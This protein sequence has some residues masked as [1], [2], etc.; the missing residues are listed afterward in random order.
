MFVFPSGSATQH[1]AQINVNESAGED[2]ASSGA[3]RYNPVVVS[4]TDHVPI[5]SANAWRDRVERTVDQETLLATQ[6]APAGDDPGALSY[7]EKPVYEL[8]GSSSLAVWPPVRLEAFD[9]PTP[10]RDTF[11]SDSDVHAPSRTSDSQVVPPE[12][13]LATAQMVRPQIDPIP[14]ASKPTCSLNLVCYRSGSSGCKLHQV[15]VTQSIKFEKTEDFAKAIMADRDLIT[16]DAE[17]FR[18]LRRAYLSEMCGFW[19]RFFF[20]KNLRGF[21]LLSVRQQTLGMEQ[22][23][24]VA[25]YTQHSRPVVVP[26]DNFVLQEILYAFNHPSKVDTHHDWIDWVFQLRQPDKRHALEFVE[27]WN[28]TRIAVAGSVPM[29]FSTL[30]GLIWSI[31]SGDWQ[32]A[33]TVASFILTLGTLL[34]A[35]LAV[36]SGI[37]A[38]GRTTT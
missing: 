1:N 18:A 12:A 23:A 3:E 7:R 33:F 35:L 14:N 19:R 37:E 29:V 32:T 10:M 31:R 25:Q 17:F 6:T 28:G 5:V 16:T 34:L 27:G 2:Q 20:L 38:S 4:D 22:V 8:D 26:L 24:N 21:R 15:Q 9:V 36:V 11:A 13:A 30:V